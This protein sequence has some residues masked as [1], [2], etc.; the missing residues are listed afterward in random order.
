LTV[1]ESSDVGYI[2]LEKRLVVYWIPDE[3]TFLVVASEATSVW[4]QDQVVAHFCVASVDAV[5]LVAKFNSFLTSIYLKHR[6][7]AF[8]STTKK[9]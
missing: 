4:I 9:R 7:R 3:N 5:S 1:A 8:A 6:R 2:D